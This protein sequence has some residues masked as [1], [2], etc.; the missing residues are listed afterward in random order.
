MKKRGWTIAGFVLILVTLAVPQGRRDGLTAQEKWVARFNGPGNG[1]DEAVAIAVDDPGNVYVTGYSHISARH[2]DYATIKYD[3][4]GK[5]LWMRSYNGPASLDDLASALAVDGSGNVYMT[6]R[7]EVSGGS[8]F[9]TIKYNTSGKRLWVKRYRGPRT[10]Y[11]N[12]YAIAVDR[13]GNVYVTGQTGY[14]IQSEDGDC[15]TI[16]Y[17]A[18]G[19]LLWVKKYNG[20]G[21]LDDGA[22]DI[23]VDAA[24]NAY[25]TGWSGHADGYDFVTMKYN[26][27]GKQLWVKRYDGPGNIDD[28]VSALD[29]DGS[30]NVYVTGYSR[31]S[32]SDSDYVTIKYDTNGNEIWVRTYSGPGKLFDFT[33]ALG[34]DGRGNVYVTGYSRVPGNSCDYATVKY[35]ANGKR[36][37]V[38]RYKGS[39]LPDEIATALA[40]DGSG[41]IHVTGY[42]HMTSSDL[43]YATVKY[44]ANGKQ[45]W[46]KRY[47][48]PAKLQDCASAIAVDGSGH[49][50]VTGF[51]KGSGTDT[52]YATVKY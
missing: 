2:F 25:I 9:A 31:L 42:V 40:L 18:N 39:G 36:L 6:G 11:H 15:T 10:L 28:R 1:R 44:D 38:R 19:K 49:V 24:G 30:G 12:P 14:S 35:N 43:D 27:N 37:W 8:E 46:A 50:Y 7:T 32:K 29:V 3:T 16:K 52:D 45:L 48:G 23:E 20:P 17:N 21:N 51:S 5:Q 4:N 26:T 47:G 34:V 41:N 13:R 22:L 33:R